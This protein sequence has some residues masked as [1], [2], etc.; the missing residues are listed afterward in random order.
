MRR[1]WRV[2]RALICRRVGAIG[3]TL[4]VLAL[5]ACGAAPAPPKS[6]G[7]RLYAANCLACHQANGEGVA[8]VQPPLA[9]TPVPLGDPEVLIAWVLFGERPASLPRG[10]YSGVMPQFGHLADADVA[11]LLTYVR[12]S[13]GNQAAPVTADMVAAV[14]ARHRG[15]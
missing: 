7:A 9:G 3:M 5:A 1:D 11:L 14:R 2:T 8:G 12:S 15:S 13:F 6:P 4:A 10:Q